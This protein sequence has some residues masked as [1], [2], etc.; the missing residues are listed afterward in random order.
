MDFLV[1]DRGQISAL[2][3]HHVKSWRI[4]ILS[5]SNRQ[6]LT[7]C[8]QQFPEVALSDGF[9]TQVLDGTAA[10]GDG[11]LRQRDRAIQSLHRLV[12]NPGK[13]VSSGLESKQGS[14][15]AL[16][17]SIVKFT[18]DSSAFRQTFL[19]PAAESSRNLTHSQPIDRPHNTD[20]GN[21]AK[22]EKPVGLI[23]GEGDIEVQNGTCVVPDAVVIAGDD[24]KCVLARPKIRVKSL[25]PCSGFLPFRVAAL[26]L[27]AK[28]HLL[29]DCEAQR[30]I[31]NFQVTR[32]R[33]NPE[34]LLWKVLLP[35]RNDFFHMHWRRHGI[36]MQ[37]SGIDHLQRR[38]VR[39]PEASVGGSRGRRVWSMPWLR[40]IEHVKDSPQLH[41]GIGVLPPLLHFLVRDFDHATLR[42]KPKV[43]GTIG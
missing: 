29:R 42:I 7:R 26:Q 11:L 34:A 28:A 30:R 25:A 37:M 2:A 27:V 36:P 18:R 3:L 43:A 20:A 24:A 10:L 1:Q 8:R 17:Q 15:K 21:D 31:V 33:R 23:P 5:L 19:K 35:V 6:F 32:K 39:K 38:A 41:D 9:R 13:H 14:V 22:S 12:W 40:T 16:Q 4:P